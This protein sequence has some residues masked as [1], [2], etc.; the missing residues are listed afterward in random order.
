LKVVPCLYFTIVCTHPPP[1]PVH[2]DESQMCELR[3]ATPISVAATVFKL[4]FEWPMHYSD[5]S[6]GN[7]WQ[8]GG[9]LPA[10]SQIGGFLWH[11]GPTVYTLSSVLAQGKLDRY[12]LVF[13]LFP[14]MR[15]ILS[16]SISFAGAQGIPK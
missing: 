7:A 5:T 10:E 15:R 2:L 13:L 11:A 6:I 1:L 8:Q 4:N 9:L 12:M 14:L 3:V 16:F